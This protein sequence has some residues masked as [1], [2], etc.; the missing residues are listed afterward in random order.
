MRNT[1]SRMFV[2][3]LAGANLRERTIACIGAAAGIAA[4]AWLV[5]MLHYDLASLP[6]LIAPIGASAV[7]LFAV[8]SSPLAQPW[9]IIGGNT[10]SALTGITVAHLIHD[11]MLAAGVA[12]GGAI[13]IMSL[14]RCLHP[15]GGAVALTAVIGGPAIFQ[16][17]YLFTFTPVALNSVALVATGLAFHRLSGHSYPHRAVT[18]PGAAPAPPLHFH[19]ESI[20]AALAD[21]GESFDVTRDDLELLLER[22]AFHEAGRPQQPRAR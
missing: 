12:V 20:D 22:A 13:L 16:A 15:P 19:T 6:L 8:P 9:S 5:A 17:E 1:L 11:P 7:L 2:P 10:I 3:L 18:V 14:A 21:L 4:T